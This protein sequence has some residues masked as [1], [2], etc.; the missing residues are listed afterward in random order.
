[1][2]RFKPQHKPDLQMDS[3]PLRGLDDLIA[4]GRACRQRL[5]HENRQ[6]PRDRLLRHLG[7]QLLRRHQKETFKLRL[8][9][10]QIEITKSSVDPKL[11]ANLPQARFVRIAYRDNPANVPGSSPFRRNGENGS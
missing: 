9:Q 7:M 8:G 1:M 6:L 3:G 10:H 2:L 5:L 4:F 11:I